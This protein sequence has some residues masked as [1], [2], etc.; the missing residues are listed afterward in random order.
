MSRRNAGSG[1]PSSRPTRELT[2]VRPLPGAGESEAA[3]PE[4][5]DVMVMP[6]EAP[7]PGRRSPPIAGASRASLYEAGVQENARLR[8]SLVRWL[9]ERNLLGAVQAM[10]EPG[11]LPMLTLRCRPRVLDQLQRAR[12]F[13][14]GTSMPMT[15]GSQPLSSH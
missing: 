3:R 8:E 5:I 12:E 2:S 13:E 11:S 4:W 10:S 6:R 9:E 7:A 15:I 1:K 14:A